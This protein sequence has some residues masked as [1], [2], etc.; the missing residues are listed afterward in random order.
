[1]KIPLN[2][3]EL[4]RKDIKVSFILMALCTLGGVLVLSTQINSIPIE[5]SGKISKTQLMVISLIQVA[6]MAF[7]TSFIGLKLSRATNLNNGL[8]RYIY[9]E[10]EGMSKYKINSKSLI[11]S[12]VA[13]FLL[14]G[15]M[16]L[17][18]KFIWAP[19]IPEVGETT[20][21][22][23]LLYLL[24]GMIY[25]GIFEEVMLRLFFMSLITLILYKLF[26]RN[27]AKND[28]PLIIYWISIFIA[29]VVF[30]L[31]HLPAT[32][33]TFGNVNGFII[34]RMLLMNGIGGVVFGYLYWKRGLEYSI[35]AHMFAH[36]FM[37]LVWLPLVF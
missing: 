31:G 9:S 7:V 37:Q 10:K 34:M 4:N 28:I 32:L 22:F 24:S 36:V 23:D 30:G 14:A 1:M 25:G 19:K 5:I 12:I 6:I 18:E 15:A 8:L 20:H 16:I 35:I 27:K 21:S 2:K 3:S 17:S 11:I 33:V 29:A 13:A 26:A